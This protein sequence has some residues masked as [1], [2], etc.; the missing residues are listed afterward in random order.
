MS[1]IPI[2][3]VGYCKFALPARADVAAVLK[4]LSQAESVEFD[5]I[6][7]EKIYYPDHASRG[8][9][10]IGVEYVD[11]SYFRAAKPSKKAAGDTSGEVVTPALNGRTPLAIEGGRHA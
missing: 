1:K 2:L 10:D 4:V 6:G 9:R 8:A 5:Y 11:D 7:S 3:S